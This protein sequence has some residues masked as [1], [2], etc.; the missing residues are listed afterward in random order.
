MLRKMS[1][2]ADYDEL[3]SKCLKC[4]RGF[5]MSAEQVP[6]VEGPGQ[7]RGAQH[8]RHGGGVARRAG[9]AHNR[10][11]ANARPEGDLR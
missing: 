4:R 1:V 3:E 2:P 11:L 9:G 7:R 10:F 6:F 8:G 5:V